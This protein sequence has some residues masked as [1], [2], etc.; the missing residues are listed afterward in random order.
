MTLDE[1]IKHA[2]EVAERIQKDADKQKGLNHGY[3]VWQSV[4]ADKYRQIAEW[5][6]ELKELREFKAIYQKGMDYSYATFMYNKAIDDL[7]EKIVGYG[8]YD[9]YGNVIDVLEI[10]EKL[11]D[12]KTLNIVHC[13]DCKHWGTG[14]AGETENVK[15]CEYGKYMVGENGYC[16]Y[17]VKECAE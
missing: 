5:L 17:G 15:C 3:Y 2:R 1:A 6:E 16:V 9:Y 8:T 4:N 13:K 14:V 11:K 12:H 10:A 7:T